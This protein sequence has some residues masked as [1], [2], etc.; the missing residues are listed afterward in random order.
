MCAIAHCAQKGTSVEAKLHGVNNR[1]EKAA[2]AYA[3]SLAQK[4]NG[5]NASTV[6]ANTFKKLATHALKTRNKS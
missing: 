1:C 4:K 2:T 6:P 3:I 5:R